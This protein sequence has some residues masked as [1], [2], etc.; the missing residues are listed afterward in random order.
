[1]A[2][3][4]AQPIISEAIWGAKEAIKK[5]I[6]EFLQKKEREAHKPKSTKKRCRN[7]DKRDRGKI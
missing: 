6:E 1:M 2:I 5:S 3:K 7:E 4:A